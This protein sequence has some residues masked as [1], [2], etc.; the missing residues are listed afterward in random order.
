[1][2]GSD[3]HVAQNPIIFS[4]NCYIKA[5]LRKYIFIKVCFKNGSLFYVWIVKDPQ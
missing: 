1:M 3:E 5:F 4:F 2:C